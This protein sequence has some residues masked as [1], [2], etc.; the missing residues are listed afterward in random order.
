VLARA[1]G[2]PVPFDRAVRGA[3]ALLDHLRAT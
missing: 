3:V 2:D 1:A